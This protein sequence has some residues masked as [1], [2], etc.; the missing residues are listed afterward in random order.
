M[1]SPQGSLEVLPGHMK[2]VT[3]NHENA[4]DV[5][6]VCL[7]DFAESMDEKAYDVVS[8]R[9]FDVVECLFDGFC[10]S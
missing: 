3:A 4:C 2:N 7:M 9:L 8:V 1:W 10:R 6:S 5:V